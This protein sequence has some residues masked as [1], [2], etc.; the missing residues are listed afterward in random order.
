MQ[1]RKQGLHGS[2]IG[3]FVFSC[4]N[5]SSRERLRFLLGGTT[6]TSVSFRSSVGGAVLSGVELVEAPF[7]NISIED[8]ESI[9]LAA[10]LK[11]RNYT[12]CVQNSLLSNP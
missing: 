8:P 10:I 1:L 3:C 4:D 11:R 6:E 2:F 7:S 12:H 5:L 9:S